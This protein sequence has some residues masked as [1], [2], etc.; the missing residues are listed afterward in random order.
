MLNVN[1]S[2]TVA[3]NV[4]EFLQPETNGRTRKRYFG[5]STKEVCQTILTKSPIILNF[6]FKVEP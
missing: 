3:Q 2:K 6:N 1:I 4:S 5:K